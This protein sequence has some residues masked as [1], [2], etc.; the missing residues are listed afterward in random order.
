MRTYRT[1]GYA[2]FDVEV[3]ANDETEALKIGKQQTE[4][5]LYN[6]D[7]NFTNIKMTRAVDS[8]TAQ[9]VRRI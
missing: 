2:Y 3:M 8:T 7:V 9:K 6:T 4:E 5:T 1:K